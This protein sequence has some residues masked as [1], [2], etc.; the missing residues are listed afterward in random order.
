MPAQDVAGNSF[1]CRGKTAWMKAAV[2]GRAH[3]ADDVGSH[4]KCSRSDGAM[5]QDATNHTRIAS[6]VCRIS[7]NFR[8]STYVGARRPT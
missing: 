2:N 7:W 8:R 5:R 1:G 3:V 4:D 6:F